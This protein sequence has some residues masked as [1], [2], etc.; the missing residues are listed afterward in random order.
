MKLVPSLMLVVT[1]L[2]VGTSA[3]AA[4]TPWTQS[5][6]SGPWSSAAT[7]VG[8]KVP[9]AGARVHVRPGHVVVYDVKSETPIRAV[10]VAGT[11]T[12]AADKDTR[13]DV[14]VLKIEAGDEPTEG[15]FDCDAHIED[16][17]A[18]AVRPALLVGTPEKPIDAKHTA[19]IRLVPFE[20]QDKQSCPAIVCCGGRM[21]FHGAPLSRTWVKLG[22]TSK[23]GDAAVTLSESVT[24]WR[25]GDRVIVTATHLGRDNGGG[26]DLL[27]TEE[28]TVTAMDGAKLMLNEPLKR[29]HLG[30]GDFRGEV[31]NLS[32]NVTVESAQ[33]EGVRGHTMYHRG[34]AGSIS[35]AEFR[36]L[37]KKDTLGRYSLHFHLVGNTMRGS[38]VIGAS[39]HNSHNRWL[40]IHG[41]NY[42]VVRDCVGYRSIG[43]G[44]FL[45]DGTE[46]QNIL[47]RNLAVQAMDGKKLP[48]QVL[49]F[50]Q[51]DGAGFWW[52]NS[53]N[54]F[55]RNVS[56]ENHHYGYFFEA[57]ETSALKLT[58]PVQQPDGSEK[59]TDIRTLP[60]VRFED[61][62]AHCDGLYGVNLGQGVNRVGPDAKHPFVLRNTKIWEIH[63]A[64]RVQ[65]PCVLVEGMTIYN[66]IYGVYHPNYDRHVYRNMSITQS[67]KHGDAEP[68]NRGHDDDS[69]QHGSLTV[70]GLTFSGH[71]QS[72][73]PL[74]Q[75]TDH[76]PTGSA[77]THIR[78]VQ[79]I[80]RQDNNR[81][82]LVNL[83]GGPRP[84]PK[85][86]T[87]V[88]VILHDFYGSGRHAR[89]V[90]AKSGEVKTEPAVY[91]SE[92]P[93]TGDESR[94]TEVRDI[95]FPNLLDPVDDLPPS[96]VITSV[97]RKSDGWLIRGWAEDNGE[98]KQVTVNG[99]AARAVRDNF[100]EWEVILAGPELTELTASA[101]DSTGNS[102][103]VPHIWKI[104]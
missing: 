38:S 28:R 21:E 79:V 92:S 50:D 23:K 91:K 60:F 57:T 30:E 83:G 12:F 66:S 2:V 7:W 102:E 78:N 29:E 62:E 49:P 19:L 76:N 80:N 104:K 98:I 74:I 40:T 95:P 85:T 10:Y 31:A 9:E 63:Y 61:N 36:H 86:P 81:R 3:N 103:K 33:P 72:G 54:T 84:N 35:Y 96:T 37:G 16:L 17:P 13:L 24:G 67:P 34:S 46:V 27:E 65:A 82:A 14:G 68:F 100:A 43:H 88:P 73:M 8:G 32:R 44:F 101:S 39:I 52:A 4:E 77:E 15:G 47:D 26:T 75:I 20:G 25:I 70:D 45:E 64:F 89:V 48:K 58:L 11:L 87:S 41:T 97:T 6:A 93:L 55:T 18:G 1:L 42:L 22:A 99:V 71:R 94:V 5:A 53:L 56:C 51:N 90:S 59:P 69:I